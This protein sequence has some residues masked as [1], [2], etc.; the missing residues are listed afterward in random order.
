HGIDPD[1]IV[2]GAGSDDLLRSLAQAFLGPGDE[3]IYTAHAF[4]MFKIFILSAGATP[5]A[6]PEKNFYADVDAI[7]AAVTP[8]TRAVF[9]A[10]PNNPTGTYIPFSEVERLRVRLPQNVLLVLDAAYSEYINEPDYQS[11]L[12]LV[13]ITANTVM[14]RTFS[15]IYGLAGARLGWCACPTKVAEILHR[16]RTPFNVP[17]PNIAAG[18]AALSDGVYV[19]Q[20]QAHNAKWLRWMTQELRAL[21]I[22]VTDSVGNF[23]LIHFDGQNKR[24]GAR[25]NAFLNERRIILRPME[26]YGL[27]NALRMTIGAE[28][29]NRAV[30]EALTEFMKRT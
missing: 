2:C 30:V 15:K 9:L 17:A 13:R 24:T 7:L 28:A 20:A 19:D 1:H 5:V 21:G 14:T 12:S 18:V 6:T 16:V 8:R 26:G 3:A 27:P 4:A 22:E 23:V 29:E 11:G 10:N 25:A